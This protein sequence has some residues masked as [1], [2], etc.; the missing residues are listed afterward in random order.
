MVRWGAVM[1]IVVAA[2]CADPHSEPLDGAPGSTGEAGSTG[3]FDPDG[4]SGLV[5]GDR[6]RRCVAPDGAG[7]PQSIPEA[8]DLLNALPPPVDI[9]CFVQSLQRPLTLHATASTFSAQPSAGPEDPRVF[10]FSGDLLMSVVSG[11]DGVRLL[12]FGQ[13]VDDSHTLKGELELPFDGTIAPSDPFDRVRYM[14]GTGCGLCHHEEQVVP[15]IDYATAFSSLALRPDRDHALEL[16]EVLA[17][18]ERCDWAETP[19]RCE[20]LTALFGHGEVVHREFP[21]YLPTIGG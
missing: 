8:I 19:Q 7:A 18:Y 3:A 5:G 10:I 13:F 9:A 16:D 2:A 20:I 14:G 12:E 17:S 1:L 15:E 6:V 4:P 21:E 11:G